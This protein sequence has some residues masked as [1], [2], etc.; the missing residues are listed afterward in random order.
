MKNLRSVAAATMIA[1][2]MTQIPAGASVIRFPAFSPAMT[3]AMGKA[4][5]QSSNSDS[6]SNSSDDPVQ[7]MRDF[8]SD[9]SRSTTPGD[10]LLPGASPFIH[11]TDPSSLDSSAD[12]GN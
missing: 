1:M 5:P 4:A 6:N 2:G 7:Q 10:L 11:S 3:V 12:G 9:P 8:T